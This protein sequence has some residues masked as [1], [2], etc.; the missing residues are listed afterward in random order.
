MVQISR[1]RDRVPASEII[2][3]F[4]PIQDEQSRGVPW[5]HAAMRRLNDLGGYREAAVVAARQGACKMG[6]YT[7]PDGQPAGIDGTDDQGNFI[8]Q[9]SPGEFG[10]LPHGYGF[11]EYNPAYPHDQF[12]A[13]CKAALRGIAGA[14]GV[15]YNGLANDLEGVNFSSIR[16][17]VLD[18]RDEW[19]VIQNFL[20]GAF[21]IPVFEEW[22]DMALLRGAITLPNGAPLP[23]AKRD[24]FAN[25]VWL[26]RRWQWVDPEK[27][28]NAAVIAIGN[29]LTSPQRVA[30]QTGTDIEDVLDE[31]AKF[32]AL[33]AEKKI[34][35]MPGPGKQAQSAPVDNTNTTTTATAAN[36]NA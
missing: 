36:A 31:I 8:M 32:Q 10:V 7:A 19:I 6:F 14:I 11:Q 20:I 27:D 25:H 2:H 35:L 24:K 22:L 34:T 18:E 4:I 15:A 33:V 30:A 12:D 17:G 16:A 13:F 1:Y 26:G 3:R 5:M 23:A 21:L 9:A 28:V 29:G